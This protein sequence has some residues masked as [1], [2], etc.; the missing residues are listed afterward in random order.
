MEDM[1][2]YSDYN[3]YEDDIPKGKSVIGLV[4][5]IL[6]G[7]V[8]IAVVGVL[9][10]R[11]VLFNR[12]PA[13]IKNIYFNDKLTAYYN[14]T[15]GDIGAVTQ[16]LRAPYDDADKGNFFCNNLIVVRDINQLQVSLRFNES[17]KENIKTEYGVD[18]DIDDPSV[19]S[20][21]LSIIPLANGST[22]I[23]TGTVS[24]PYTDSSFMYRY[25]KL[26]F[27]D[28]AFEVDGYDEF[29]IRLEIQ[30]DGVNNVKTKEPEV[31]MVLVY[32]DSETYGVFNDYDLSAKER[33]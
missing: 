14:E 22:P 17:L 7:L 4:L 9:V 31:F 25:F 23:S 2:R 24:V 5:K 8:C 16:S 11:I 6:V 13:N 10:F 18:I 30:I 21:N 28:V 12:Y 33:P 26:V 27:D 1:E 15:D 19:F 29:W 20:F 32:E 3:E